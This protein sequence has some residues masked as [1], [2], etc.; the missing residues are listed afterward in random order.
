MLNAPSAR[1]A[2]LDVPVLKTSLLLA[3]APRR[4]YRQRA[5]EPRQNKPS[6]VWIAP[7]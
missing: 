6:G 7:A 2:S 1:G 4:A 3:P 5:D